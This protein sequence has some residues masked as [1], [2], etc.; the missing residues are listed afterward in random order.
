MPPWRT[1]DAHAHD[2]NPRTTRPQ[3]GSNSAIRPRR[4]DSSSARR[5]SGPR[6]AGPAR[7]PGGPRTAP[8]LRGLAHRGP[9]RGHAAA[10]KRSLVASNAAPVWRCVQVPRVPARMA[11]TVR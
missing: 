5:P 4:S 1:L 6:A 8:A 2:W 7:G 11:V 10:A 3:P 9:H